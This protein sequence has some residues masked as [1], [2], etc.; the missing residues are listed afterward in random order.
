MPWKY[1]LDS[2]ILE[3][4]LDLAFHTVQ[5]HAFIKTSDQ[6]S[7]IPASMPVRISS[8]QDFQEQNHSGEVCVIA[9]RHEGQDISEDSSSPSTVLPS[10]VTAV[11]YHEIEILISF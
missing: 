3:I 10:C 7:H 1:G 6:N 2:A 5:A 8:G 11:V 4:V 9:A